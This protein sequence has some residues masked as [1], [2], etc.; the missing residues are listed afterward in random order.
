METAN[1]PLSDGSG[2]RLQFQSMLPGTRFR[3]IAELLVDRTAF[4]PIRKL[5]CVM[6]TAGLTGLAAGDEH[7]GLVPV[8]DVGDESH[9]G[10]VVFC[11]CTRA[12]SG[13]GLRLV[14]DAE[15]SL[16]KACAAQWMD[17][18]QGVK[19]LPGPIVDS[20]FVAQLRE[21]RYSAV[22]GRGQQLIVS[23]V[24]Y[25]QPLRGALGQNF[26]QESCSS[27]RIQACFFAEIRFQEDSK[28]CAT[29]F[30]EEG[31]LWRIC[32]GDSV[33]IPQPFDQF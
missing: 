29:R 20:R 17:H 33:P 13:A 6:R 23:L 30:L 2:R 5:I 12:V 1:N 24:A 16:E 14:G 10:A 3:Y 11:R 22:R 21:A 18:V 15:E 26:L 27:P 8:A 19:L 7:D 4:V 25:G 32:V 28:R 9:G 31:N